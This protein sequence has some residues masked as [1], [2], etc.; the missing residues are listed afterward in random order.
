MVIQEL[1]IQTRDEGEGWTQVDW[2]QPVNPEDH[3]G[4]PG[5]EKLCEIAR[6]HGCRFARVRTRSSNDEEWT[7]LA[8]V[9]QKNDCG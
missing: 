6:Q 7:T 8:E 1:S 5:R 4:P 3:L 9:D 2:G